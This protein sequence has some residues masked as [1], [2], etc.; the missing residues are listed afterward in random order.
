MPVVRHL[1]NSTFIIRCSQLLPKP[2]LAKPRHSSLP[3]A[4]PKPDSRRR[5]SA[6]P[7]KWRPAAWER[8]WAA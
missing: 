5:L 3:S 8:E 7:A 2:Q 6:G 1:H 4:R